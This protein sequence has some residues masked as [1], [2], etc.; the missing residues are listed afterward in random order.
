M[1]RRKTQFNVNFNR[2]INFD[3]LITDVS[4]VHVNPAHQ[5]SIIAAFQAKKKRRAA[6]NQL[7]ALFGKADIH[8]VWQVECGR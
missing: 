2:Y 8:P 7:F 1:T 3:T 4:R 6:V 5:D